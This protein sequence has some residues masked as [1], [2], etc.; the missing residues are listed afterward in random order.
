MAVIISAQEQGESHKLVEQGVV[1]DGKYYGNEDGKTM[2][3]I[4]DLDEIDERR[5]AGSLNSHYVNATIVPDEEVD[6]DR[7][8]QMD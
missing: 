2:V 1:I 7:F 3:P 8:R 4:V 5:L 6:I